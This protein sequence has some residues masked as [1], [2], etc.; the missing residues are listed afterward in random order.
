M[1]A[2]VEISPIGGTGGNFVGGN[3]ST[4]WY[5]VYVE[6]GTGA[7]PSDTGDAG[8]FNGNITV[9]GAIN[10]APKTSGSTTR[11]IGDDEHLHRQYHHG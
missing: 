8:Y 2:G 7:Y 4:G 5:G 3:G 11:S 1:A 10:A 9:T 6:G